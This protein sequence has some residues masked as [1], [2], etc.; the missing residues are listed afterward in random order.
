MGHVMDEQQSSIVFR[1]GSFLSGQ[2]SCMCYTEDMCDMSTVFTLTAA[3]RS[4]GSTATDK[5]TKRIRMVRPMR[6]GQ[7]CTS[8]I[9]D[10]RALRSNDD[11]ARVRPRS[12]RP[13]SLAKQ[14][15]ADARTH[16]G[17]NFQS[18]HPRKEVS[19]WLD[20]PRRLKAV[21]REAR[22]SLSR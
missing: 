22:V 4:V 11:F 12:V 9:A 6:M 21:L 20:R 18:F 19:L 2:Q 5:A 8:K 16:G 10:F 7:L 17:V 1:E 14:R 15:C 3:P 13:C